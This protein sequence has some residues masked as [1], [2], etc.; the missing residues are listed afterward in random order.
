M[1]HFAKLNSDNKVIDVVVVNNE[2]LLDE[3]NNEVEAKGVEFLNATLGTAE[4]V[5]TSYNGSFRAKYAGVGDSYDSVNDKFIPPQP[6]AGWTYNASLNSWVAPSDPPQDNNIYTWDEENNQW[7][8][9]R[10]HIAPNN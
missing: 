10:Q 7:I 5:Q 3:N 1:A 4:W 8:F 9:L 6:Y 2:V